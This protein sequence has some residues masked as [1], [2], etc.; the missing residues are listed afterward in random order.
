[1]ILETAKAM[2]HHDKDSTVCQALRKHL[3]K[4]RKYDVTILVLTV[5]LVLFRMA[6]FVIGGFLTF[7]I[8]NI[9]FIDTDQV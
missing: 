3:S 6:W 1:M 2:I 8:A 5:L 7:E 4:S 9:V